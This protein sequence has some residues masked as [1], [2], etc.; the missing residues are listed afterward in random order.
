MIRMA[1][2]AAK[3]RFVK[4]YPSEAL[5]DPD[6]NGCAPAKEEGGRRLTPLRPCRI[7]MAMSV[8]KL[9]RRGEKTYP[10]EALH[11]PDG[12]ECSKV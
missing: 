2:S 1:M 9:R 3:S 11:D 6:G 12:D 5:H 4:T 8:T 10:S 7:K